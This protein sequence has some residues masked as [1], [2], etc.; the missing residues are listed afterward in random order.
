MAGSRF[1]CHAS[2]A[3]CSLTG[4]VG[5]GGGRGKGMV[6]VVGRRTGGGD[7]EEVGGGVKEEDWWGRWGGGLMKC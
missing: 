3:P 4:E 1:T 6:E 2:I 7:D 5:A